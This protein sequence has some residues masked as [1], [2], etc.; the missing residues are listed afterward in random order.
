MLRLIEDSAAE[1]GSRLEEFDSAEREVNAGVRGMNLSV[2]SARGAELTLALVRGEIDVEEY[3]RESVSL[4]NAT[5]EAN[6]RSAA[7][8]VASQNEANAAVQ[9]GLARG[10]DA[11]RGLEDS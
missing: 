9:R 1:L 2:H 11:W 8:L 6:D 5:T 10:R 3:A 4:L 7:E